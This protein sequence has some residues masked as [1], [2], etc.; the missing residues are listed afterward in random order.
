[1]YDEDRPPWWLWALM[2]AMVLFTVVCAIV[3]ALN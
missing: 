3:A 1:M 2:A